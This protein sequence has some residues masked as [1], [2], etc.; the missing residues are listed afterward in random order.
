M[1]YAITRH[2]SVEHDIENIQDFIVPV[3]GVRIAAK[4]ARE[5]EERIRKLRDYPHIGTIHSSIT[6]GLR[7]LPAAEK[8]VIC[9]TV[10]DDAHT[11]KIICVTYAG[12]DWQAIAGQRSEP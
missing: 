1:R 6:P 2:P 11:V 4:I 9:F 7:A 8:G 10:D 5:I 12:Q 3:A